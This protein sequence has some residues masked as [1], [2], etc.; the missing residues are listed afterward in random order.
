MDLERLP[1]AIVIVLTA[2]LAGLGLWYAALRFRQPRLK[3]V[4]C[5]VGVFPILGFGL[6]IAAY[7]F[8]W[9]R[10]SDTFTTTTPGPASRESSVTRDFP[11]HVNDPSLVHE[12]ELTPRAAA[13]KTAEGTIQLTMGVR[14]P[15]G[16]TLVDQTATLAPGQGP[17]WSPLRARFQPREEGE[18]GMHLEIPAGVDEVKVKVRELRK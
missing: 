9:G 8:D 14:S 6:Q 12:I 10:P 11:F 16:E 15:R 13:G 7:F 2:V 4:A 1:T 18:H 5:M 3:M 17:F